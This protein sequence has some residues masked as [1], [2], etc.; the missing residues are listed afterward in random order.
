MYLYTMDITL[1]NFY[2]ICQYFW[3]MGHQFHKYVLYLWKRL[4][5]CYFI[6]SYYYPYVIFFLKFSRSTLCDASDAW[7]TPFPQRLTVPGR[8]PSAWVSG[9]GSGRLC[10][11][12]DYLCG[13]AGSQ[14]WCVESLLRCIWDL[15]SPTRDQTHIPYIERRILNHRTTREVPR[16]LVCESV[17][18]R[19]VLCIAFFS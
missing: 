9:T 11:F 7:G 15:S 5:W 14:L 4:A 8:A 1:F 2:L 12:S 19:T 17:L 10:S 6:V 18:W 16:L 3:C 13:C